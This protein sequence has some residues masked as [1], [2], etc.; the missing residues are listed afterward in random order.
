MHSPNWR[1]KCKPKM[2]TVGR[3][4]YPRI[5]DFQRLRQ[6]ADSVGALLFVDM[7]HIAGLGRG[8]R[9][10]KPDAA[11]G[12]RHDDDAQKLARTAR[13][14]CSLP[15]TICE[16]DRFASVFPGVQGGPLMHVIAAKAVCFHEALQPSFHEYQQQVVLNAKALAAGVAKHGFRI[17]S[18]GTDNHLMLVDLRPKEINGKD[19]AGTCSTTPA[20]R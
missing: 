14:D 9:T 12:F 10:S 6:I 5:I 11:R 3:I 8:R 7:A 4:A 17:V 19:R 15:G 13:R 1:Q 20:S 16:G 18:G 2:I